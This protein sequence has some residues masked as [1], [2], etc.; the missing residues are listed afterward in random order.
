MNQISKKYL[1]LTAKLF[2]GAVIAVL[3][4]A[5]VQ[6]TLMDN[7][8]DLQSSNISLM[9]IEINLFE[10]TFGES[11]NHCCVTGYPGYKCD[12]V[13]GTT[14]NALPCGVFTY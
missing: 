9:G 1:K 2:L 3:V 6:L 13:N 11:N 10:S 8:S 5:N 12:H 14:Y 4:F 7:D